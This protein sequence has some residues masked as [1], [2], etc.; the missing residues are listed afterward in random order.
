MHKTVSFFP[1]LCKTLLRDDRGRQDGEYSLVEAD[2]TTT[3]VF[4]E[5]RG[6]H[7]YTFYPRDV[8]VAP[9]TDVAVDHV[10]VRHLR[11]NGNQ[12]DTEM[13]Q[14]RSY[15]TFKLSVQYNKYDGYARPQNYATMAPY[16]Y[17]GFLPQIIAKSKSTQGYRANGRDFTFTNCDANP[18]SYMALFYN[19]K[20]KSPT[21]YH[22]KCCYNKFMR[23]W[24]DVSI[25]ATH[26]LPSKYFFQIEMHMGG[27]GGY[28]V[29]GYNTF[30][31]IK[32]AAVGIPFTLY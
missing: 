19:P 1:D 24:V 8:R 18:N 20:N 2:G 29:N 10:I 9:P 13:Q 21:N 26:N 5:F 31:D 32:G 3:T 7:G 11:S 4:C 28:I 17:L 15:T 6:N 16:I 27:C 25:P 12:F 23:Q 30:S 22:T 14:I